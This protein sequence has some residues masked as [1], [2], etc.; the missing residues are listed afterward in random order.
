M[1]KFVHFGNIFD[2]NLT[3]QV[4]AGDRGHAEALP[5]IGWSLSSPNP[6]PTLQQCFYIQFVFLFANFLFNGFEILFRQTRPSGDEII[7]LG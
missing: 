3:P 1:G 7:R 2:Q 5:L 4:R 6:H